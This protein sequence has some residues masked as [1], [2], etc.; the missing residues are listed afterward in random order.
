MEV[1]SEPPAP[2]AC[3]LTESL[4]GG[5]IIVLNGFPGTGKFTILKRVKD[6][7]PPNKTRLLDNH[8]LIDPVHAIY[9]DR[10]SQHHALRRLLRAPVFLSLK[11][12]AIEEGYVILMTACLAQN[13]ERDAAVLD[14]H[15]A[16][17]RGTAIP[18][19][20]IN[21]HC[22]ARILEQRV[23]TPERC[24]SGKSKLTDVDVLRKM[25]SE[26]SLIQ[27][28]AV[29]HASVNLVVETLDV[30]GTVENSVDCLMNMA[31][32][33]PVPDH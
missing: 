2:P 22:D 8:L 33:T 3:L 28:Q 20:W 12:L 10:S 26:H 9:P 32:L 29:D 25:L 30:S 16:M 19:F 15:L 13:N 1:P 4:L 31:G 7:L 6:I 24:G 5:K 11:Q 23:R 14:E 27:P 18:L 17:V 21:V